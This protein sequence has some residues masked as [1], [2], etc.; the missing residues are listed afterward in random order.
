MF[1]SRSS[2]KMRSMASKSKFNFR[3]ELFCSILVTVASTLVYK[4]ALRVVAFFPTLGLIAALSRPG[5]FFVPLV[6]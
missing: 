3:F 6:L 2:F 5:D 4:S 1:S